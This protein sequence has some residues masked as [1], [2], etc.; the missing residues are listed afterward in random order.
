VQFLKD[1]EVDRSFTKPSEELLQTAID[2]LQ[3][4]IHKQI[5]ELRVKPD[6]Q[7]WFH[8][9]LDDSLSSASQTISFNY[10]D[11]ALLAEELRDFAMDIEVLKP[12]E[13]EDLVR[14]GFEKVASDH[15]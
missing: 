10:M 11:L 9:R 8:F 2:D 3:N 5:C 12:K 15:A 6:S 1:G 4:H 7:A 13:L 14:A